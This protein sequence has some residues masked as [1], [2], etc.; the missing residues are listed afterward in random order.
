MGTLQ[1]EFRHRVLH[2]RE[3]RRLECLL[4]MARGTLNAEL[5]TDLALMIVCVAVH[6]SPCGQEEALSKC[7]FLRCEL[8]ALLA[9]DNDVPSHQLVPCHVVVKGRERTA[10]PRR[11][12]MARFA[13]MLR[14][15]RAMGCRMARLA[16][17]E[18]LRLEIDG[19]SFRC[20]P[21]MALFAG[22]RRVFPKKREPGTI[23][24]KCRDN[25]PPFCDVAG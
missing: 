25:V 2:H 3:E 11:R 13:L 20:H 14:K 6:A 24:V 19:L 9:L 5:S 8:M 12:S 23:V 15:C 17:A 16:V 18:I 22:D 4:R 21:H 1:G 7:R 10:V